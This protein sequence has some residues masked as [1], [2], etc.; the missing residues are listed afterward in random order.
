M[1]PPDAQPRPLPFPFLPVVEVLPTALDTLD[2]PLSGSDD[3]YGIFHPDNFTAD[4]SSWDLAALEDSL[5]NGSAVFT[6]TYGEPATLLTGESEEL[7]GP[8][9]EPSEDPSAE[10]IAEWVRGTT[11]QTSAETAMEETMDMD[12]ADTTDT[13][14]N[15]QGRKML[16]ARA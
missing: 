12:S 4:Y 10:T 3:I 16:A 2:L 8:T 13:T 5:V 7:N 1:G 9:V 14:A 11:P 6:L 15:N